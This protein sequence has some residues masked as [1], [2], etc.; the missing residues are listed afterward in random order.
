M[1]RSEVQ[2]YVSEARFMTKGGSR[3]H[4]YFHHVEALRVRSR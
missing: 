2:F 1:V 4:E 3:L